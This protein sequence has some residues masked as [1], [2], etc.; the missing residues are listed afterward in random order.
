[1]TTT[2]YGLYVTDD[3]T[4]RFQDVRQALYGATD[5]NMTKIDNILF[6]KADNSVVVY[7]T[8]AAASWTGSAAPY[9]QTI[10][11]ANMTEDQNGVTCVA[12]TATIE[13]REAARNAALFI[14]A[15]NDNSLT[16]AADGVLPTVDIPV[17]VT[18][19]G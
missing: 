13:Q 9:Q 17:M 14:A 15:Q 7:A 16:L 10:A 6:A 5:S 3:F 8:L 1:M 19:L 4:A 18:L 12:N 2:N 11:V